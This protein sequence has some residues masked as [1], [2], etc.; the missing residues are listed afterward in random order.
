MQM[1]MSAVF[2]FGFSAYYYVSYFMLPKKNFIMR[3]V[4]AGSIR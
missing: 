4:H 3:G 1:M 2:F